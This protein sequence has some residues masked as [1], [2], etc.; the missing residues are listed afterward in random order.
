MLYATENVL[1]SPPVQTME[2]HSVT[3]NVCA[4]SKGR[5]QQPRGLI[6]IL[7]GH[8]S[9][10]AGASKLKGLRVGISKTEKSPTIR[11]SGGETKA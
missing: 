5:Q 1:I 11:E 9:P 4:P 6:K 8:G 2:E 3:Q 7:Y 10:R